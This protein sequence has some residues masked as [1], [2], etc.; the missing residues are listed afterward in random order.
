MLFLSFSLFL[1]S[2]FLQQSE[3]MSVVPFQTPENGQKRENPAACVFVA[4]YD[5][6][7]S[8]PTSTHGLNSCSLNRDLKDADLKANVHEHFLQW[9]HIMSVK[10]FRD[11]LKRPYA[12]VQYEVCL[13][14]ISSKRTES[15]IISHMVWRCIRLSMIVNKH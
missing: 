9:G 3:I 7:D 6:R 13:C 10:V 4:R 11:W 8:W 14:N 5:E 15:L 2:L 12:F 1:L